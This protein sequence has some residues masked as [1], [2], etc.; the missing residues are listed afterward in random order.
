[1]T[2]LLITGADGFV[3]RH[4]CAAAL[5]AGHAVRGAVRAAPAGAPS[6]PVAGVEWLPVGDLERGPDWG[7]A[8]AGVD[9]VV[10]LAGRAHVPSRSGPE[11]LQAYRDVNVTP[12]RQL[13]EAM[14]ARGVRRLVFVSTVLV[15][16]Q[17]SGASPFAEDAP[18]RP[19][20]AYARTKWEAEEWLRGPGTAGLD[21]VIVRPVLVYG[22]GVKGNLRRLLRWLAQGWPLPLA[23]IHN[24][25]SLVDV[26]QLCALLLA[27]AMRPDAAGRVFL[28]ADTLPLSTPEM[29][30]SLATGLGRPARLFRLP[31]P[32]LR[33]TLQTAGLGH[34][35]TQLA[36]TL[37][38]DGSAA[39][40][41]MGSAPEADP[42]SGLA[43]MARAFLHGEEGP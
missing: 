3:G 9:A 10:H 43:A 5:R 38:A 16:G 31:G 34:T 41:W 40:S 26:E 39:R 14:H 32:L 30:R 27:C 28:A 2:T 1:M 11:T 22:P 35:W 8:L 4:L 15:H 12:T 42:R 7:G 21:P 18:P 13:A 25:R 24:A 6:P 19:G 37:V 17:V 29:V 23:G 33:A 36:G 20:R